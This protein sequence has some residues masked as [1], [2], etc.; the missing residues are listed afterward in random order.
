MIELFRE[1]VH[2]RNLLY[3][4][5]WRE[6]KVRYKQSVMGILWALLMPLM[7]ISAGTLVRLAFSS[8]S[9]TQITLN[10]VLALSA[11]SAPYA[12]I[13]G[14][15]RFG[16]VSL[17]SNSSLL[18]KIYMPRLVFP[19]AAVASQ[20]FDFGVAAGILLVLMSIGGV[21]VSVQLLWVPLLFLGLLL[22]ALGLAILLSAAS[23]FF[24]DVKYLVD[25]LLTFAVFFTPVF[26][27]SSMFGRWAP[28]ILLNPIAP[29][30]EGF[31]ATIVDHRAPDLAW[32]A[33]SLVFGLILGFGSIS[34]FTKLE[35]YFAE[36][37]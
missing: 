15:I 10:E 30:L 25:A 17:V 16:T 29:L 2:A 12:F 20:L 22:L 9:D 32:V 11:K 36:S 4:L 23:L 1:M 14:S 13:V 24:R 3:I 33:Y 35:P 7:V 8:L 27:D 26:Y 28:A 37:V 6:I 19:V 31:S 34:M 18:T 21:G 5:A